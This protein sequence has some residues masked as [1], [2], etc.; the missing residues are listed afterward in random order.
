VPICDITSDLRNL[1]PDAF[2]RLEGARG[3]CYLAKYDLLFVFGS[4]I[5]IN[6]SYKGKVLSKCDVH[7]F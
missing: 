3:R 6:L 2:E 1:P 7:F 4:T 5:E